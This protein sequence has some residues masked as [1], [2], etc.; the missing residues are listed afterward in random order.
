MEVKAA[1][2]M[3]HR[4]RHQF[5]PFSECVQEGHEPGHQQT[6]MLSPSDLSLSLHVPFCIYEI[7]RTTN[8]I[9]KPCIQ[10]NLSQVLEI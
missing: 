4:T 3:L 7:G 8:F 1:S 6:Q 9:L 10:C 2:V 5:V